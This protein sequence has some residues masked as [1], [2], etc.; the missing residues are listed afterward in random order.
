MFF[1]EEDDI[2][3][4][5]APISRVK[6]AY[7]ALFFVNGQITEQGAI[8]LDDLIKFTRLNG[9]SACLDKDGRIDTHATILAEGRREVGLRLI[10]FLD[11]GLKA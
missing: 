6:N 2:E 10:K 8:V 9:L 5:S 4:M 7:K 3:L 11:M 1:E